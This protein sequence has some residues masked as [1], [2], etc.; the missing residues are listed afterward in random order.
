VY[1]L[2]K[3]ALNMVTHNSLFPLNNVNIQDTQTQTHRARNRQSSY[4]KHS[5]TNKYL[6]FEKNQQHANI[7]YTQGTSYDSY[8]RRIIN[9]NPY[10]ISFLLNHVVNYWCW[11]INEFI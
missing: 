9:H 2:Q 5:S 10:I 7:L 4:L 1:V 11:T 6:I 3:Y 8:A